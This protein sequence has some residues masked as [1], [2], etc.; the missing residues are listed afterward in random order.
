MAIPSTLKLRIEGMDCGA[1][2]VK[3]ENA[4]KRLPGVSDINVSYGQESLSLTL[5]EDRTSPE[6][7]EAKIKAL[8]F[9]PLSNAQRKSS[10]SADA[11]E[12]NAPTWWRTRKGRFVMF[13]GAMF[14]IAFA[15]AQID[16]R[17]GQWAYS[18]AALVSIV[19]VLKRVYA[20]AISGTPF[21][22]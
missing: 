9:T 22:I 4:M 5:D 19:P 3:I 13:T 18:I 12:R 7:I 17:V 15:L 14:A 6:S 21:S 11:D 16:P 1:C 8:G 10:A 2:A 20:G